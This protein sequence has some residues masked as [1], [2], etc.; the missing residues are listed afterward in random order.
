MG[1]SA[2]RMKLAPE[3]VVR[4]PNSASTRA[5]LHA[6][7]A[8]AFDRVSPGRSHEEREAWRL[9]GAQMMIAL[10]PEHLEETDRSPDVL[11]ER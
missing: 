7:A 8:A 3:I 10:A 9:I 5:A 1:E 2:L 11:D 6:L 4:I